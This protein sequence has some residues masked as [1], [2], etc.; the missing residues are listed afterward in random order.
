MRRDIRLYL[1]DILEAC[2]RITS[3]VQGLNPCAF[4]QDQRTL[5]AVIRNL[6]VIGEAARAIPD[7]VRN[8]APEIEWYKIVGMR[9]LL[10]HE[11]FGISPVILWDVV[12]S[13]LNPLRSA[14]ER[15]LAL[16]PDE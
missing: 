10:V 13:K 6:E 14:C 1:D 3:Y 12:K 4:A 11:Y 5:D 16:F 7:E 2:S 8:E 9:N 15:L